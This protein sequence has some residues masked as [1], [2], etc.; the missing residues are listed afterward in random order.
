[1]IKPLGE[2]KSDV[3][4]LCELAEYLK[5]DD[6]L[7][8]SGYEACV[9]FL[10]EGLHTTVEELRSFEVPMQI[11]DFSPEC[12]MER[13]K[14]GLPT[15]TGKFEL[16]S[17]LIAAHPE[18][19]LDAL[20]TYVPPVTDE[21]AARFPM[22]LC[23]GARIPN[24]I[25]SRLHD[26]PWERALKPIPTAEINDLDAA[27]LG[28]QEGDS[29]VICTATG[30]LEITAQISAQIPRNQ[31]YLFHGYREADANLLTGRNNLDPY[32]GFPAFRSTA[33]KILKKE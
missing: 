31:V 30:S 23:A 1:M 27:A 4:I 28:I 6:P 7:L 25:H 17:E 21:E 5:L 9:R 3:D 24:A 22:L 2:A 12:P 13:L 29:I 18:W 8:R 19:G 32:S 16:K 26:V 14:N 10:I 20:P 15:P 11:P 33:C